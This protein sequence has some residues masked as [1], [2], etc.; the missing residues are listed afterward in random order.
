MTRKYDY[1]IFPETAK[2][3]VG[4]VLAFLG[5]ILVMFT[6]FVLFITGV[7]WTTVSDTVEVTYVNRTDSTVEVYLNHHPH[8]SVPP[9][10]EVTIKYYTIFWEWIPDFEVR[11]P[12]GRVITAAWYDEEDLERLDYRIVID[13]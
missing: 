9:G 8:T 13:D 10:E 12:Q 11:D 7:A 3:R 5:G 6:Y 1:K 2:A 4:L